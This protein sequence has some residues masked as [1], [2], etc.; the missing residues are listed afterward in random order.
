MPSRRTSDACSLPWT[1]RRRVERK[2]GLRLE[3]AVAVVVFAAGCRKSEPSASEN[4]SASGSAPGPEQ[5]ANPAPSASSSNASPPALTYVLKGRLGAAAAPFHLI[6]ENRAGTLTALLDPE[7]DVAPV[8]LEGRLEGTHVHLDQVV[9]KGKGKGV[10]IDGTM[11]PHRSSDGGAAA[12]PSAEWD[13]SESTA[14]EL[15]GTF[16][17]PKAKSGTPAQVLVA[18]K[19]VPFPSG[20]DFTQSYAGSIGRLRVRI[21]LE[22]KGGAI[23]GKYRYVQ[24][25]EDIALRG[26]VDVQSGAFQLQEGVGDKVTGKWHGHFLDASAVVGSWESRT[27]PKSLPVL[28]TSGAEFP[29]IV[30][31]G[32]GGKVVPQETYFAP[33]AHCVSSI[34]YPL[35]EDLPNARA[36]ATLNGILQSKAV[37]G[38]LFTKE[39]CEGATPELGYW[40]EGSYSVVPKKPGYFGLSISGST[41]T[42]GAHEAGFGECFVVDVDKA[43]LVDLQT[44][45]APAPGGRARLSKMV[46]A[47]IKRDNPGQKLTDAGFFKDDIEVSDTTSLCLAPDGI[48]VSFSPYEIA[49]WSMGAP[50]VTI[51]AKD[52][53]P[54]FSPSPLVDAVLK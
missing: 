41:F 51:A 3:I 46:D 44:L 1:P 39:T 26:R 43:A 4:P 25:K 30:A 31:L 10:V 28:L 8:A 24:S 48:L 18:D 7:G 34:L 19:N 54:L 15:R 35:L 29:E 37:S 21:K 27:T 5:A 20:A 2:L 11:A 32:G 52:A 36:A 23:T 13:G 49:P 53:L 40:S 22:V 42:G 47:K 6:I 38:R 33:V 50:Q 9:A 45:L 14:V 16:V 12:A 17:D